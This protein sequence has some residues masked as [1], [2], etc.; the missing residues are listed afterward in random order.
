LK[1]K[2]EKLID[3][4]VVVVASGFITLVLIII[5]GVTIN[6]G[7]N[8]FCGIRGPAYEM[9]HICHDPN[10]RCEVE[11]GV[12]DLN[13]TGEIDGCNCLCDDDSTVSVCSGWREIK[14]KNLKT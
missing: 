12:Y 6:F 8:I 14:W 1:T 9:D 3:A 10:L 7:I 13:F 11:C 5:I 4:F 2:L